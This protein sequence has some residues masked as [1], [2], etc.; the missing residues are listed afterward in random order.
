MAWDSYQA[1]NLSS[2]WKS[3]SYL[4][5]FQLRAWWVFLGHPA[6]VDF[7][8]TLLSILWHQA[9]C[10]T[11]RNNYKIRIFL[12]EEVWREQDFHIF[13]WFHNSLIAYR[14]N[15]FILS[16]LMFSFYPNY[17]NQIFWYSWNPLKAQWIKSSTSSNAPTFSSFSFSSNESCCQ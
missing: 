10:C 14:S 7:Y 8:G 15:K 5:L 9:R 1:W 13:L 16:R 6:V 2:F 4:F 17:G 3:L 11:L 12:K